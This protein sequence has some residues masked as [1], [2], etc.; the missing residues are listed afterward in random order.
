L[1]CLYQWSSDH[2][3]NCHRQYNSPIEKDRGQLWMHYNRVEHAMHM[4]LRGGAC[5]TGV[6][7]SVTGKYDYNMC[8]I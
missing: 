5:S 3:D 4:D 2:N 7:C 6:E 8:G 1:E